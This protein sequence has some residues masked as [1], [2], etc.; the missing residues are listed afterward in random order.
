MVLTQRIRP[1]TSTSR[2]TAPSHCAGRKLSNNWLIFDRKL[3]VTSCRPFCEEV[4]KRD[5]PVTCA[6]P[7]LPCDPTVA[8]FQ[9]RYVF[10]HGFDS[11]ILWV[12]LAIKNEGVSI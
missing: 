3:S 9:P 11:T 2:L 12:T 6:L 8:C 5:G 1:R 10:T 7:V 4:T